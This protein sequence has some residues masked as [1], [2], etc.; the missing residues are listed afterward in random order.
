MTLLKA[1]FAALFP[2]QNRGKQIVYIG[3]LMAWAL[4]QYAL[5][6]K[7]YALFIIAFFL[8]LAKPRPLNFM[9]IAISVLVIVLFKTS[10]PITGAEL[11]E[12][13]LNAIQNYKITLFHVFTPDSGQEALPSTVRYMLSLLKSNHV[14]SYQLSDQLYQNPLYMQRIVE[15]AWPIKMDGTS[16]YRLSLS[17]EINDNTACTTIDQMKDVVL[18][19]CH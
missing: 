17:D 10:T 11:S 3:F 16:S 6:N 5:G 19:Y 12:Q 9:L 18:A 7:F 1:K 13:N 2:A 15:S 4:I 14:T 8:I